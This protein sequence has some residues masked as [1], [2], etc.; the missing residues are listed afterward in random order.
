M[1]ERDFAGHAQL[2]PNPRTIIFHGMIIHAEHLSNPPGVE[3]LFG[4]DDEPDLSDRE[5][6]TFGMYSDKSTE[7][8]WP[9]YLFKRFPVFSL[10]FSLCFV[11]R[12][13]HRSS[14]K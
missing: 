5:L 14:C 9:A 8:P 4:K 1:T 7:D 13:S 11:F 10:L 12:A 6:R 2:L 3:S